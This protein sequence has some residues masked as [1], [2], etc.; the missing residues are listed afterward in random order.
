MYLHSTKNISLRV[1][2]L[3]CTVF[4]FGSIASASEIEA[5]ALRTMGQQAKHIQFEL[6]SNELSA[7]EK[8][9]DPFV[10]PAVDI[11][12]IESGANGKIIIRGNNTI[13]QAVGLNWYLKYV[14]KTSISWWADDPIE[15][16]DA[17]PAVEN[18]I[19][20][21]GQT[22]NR[23]FLNYCTFGYTMPWWNW[24]DWERLIDWMALNGINMPLAIT[25][26]EAIWQKV[27]T[28]M[29]LCDLQIRTFFTGPAHLPWHRM[30][31]ID[32]WSGPLPQSY[33]D[34]QFELQKRILAR[35]RALGMTPI[36]PAFAG[37]V[38]EALK[39]ISPKSKISTLG[40]WGGILQEN[41]AF[42]LD[43][44]DPLFLKIQELFLTEQ[45]KH[46]GTNHIYGADP[47]N[48]VTP[49]SWRLNI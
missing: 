19:R 48:E 17:L 9:E 16:P 24:H 33:I 22:E 6:I 44:S 7:A 38:P 27:W 46:F 21:L 26:Q 5:L 4:L 28:Q 34:N 49:P 47:F 37:H 10:R 18:K 30:S 12:E 1:S 3:V 42:Y 32:E 40:R 45:T 13:S 15:L 25:G 14:C 2:M 23:F 39:E 36:L 29:G 20:K 8:N 41:W 31:N 11:F 35:E 43:P